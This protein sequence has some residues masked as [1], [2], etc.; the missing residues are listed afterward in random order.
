MRFGS[1]NIGF[2]MK[3]TAKN[4]SAFAKNEFGQLTSICYQIY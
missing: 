3:L 2:G 4:L 1:Q